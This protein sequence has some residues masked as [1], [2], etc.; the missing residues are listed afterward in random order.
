MQTIRLRHFLFVYA[1]ALS[2]LPA[3]GQITS[4]GYEP[5]PVRIESVRNVKPRPIN[6]KDLLTLRDITGVSISPDGRSVAY[7]VSQAVQETNS[8]RTALFVVDTKPGSVPRNM[9]SAGPPHWDRV[10]QYVKIQ[11]KWSPDSRYI[12]LLMGKKDHKRTWLWNREGGSPKQL[13]HLEADVRNQDQIG[14][15]HSIQLSLR[16]GF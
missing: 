4:P 15:P 9:G 1:M 3:Q 2:A 5:S 11:P 13:T 10:G 14:G 8:Y 12:T 16:I 7:V 6:S